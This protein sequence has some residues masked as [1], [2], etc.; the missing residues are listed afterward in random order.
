[1]AGAVSYLGLVFKTH[2]LLCDSTL[3]SRVMNKKKEE[4]VWR[5]SYLAE[6]WRHPAT[7]ELLCVDSHHAFVN[8][9][10]SACEG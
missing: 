6:D 3:G 9:K 8:N 10:P 1:M 5:G 4:E 2:R 7:L